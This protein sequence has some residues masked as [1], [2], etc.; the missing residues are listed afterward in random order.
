MSSDR[1]EDLL[2]RWEELSE[3]G[4]PVSPEELCRDCPELLDE[5]RRRV[6]A[7]Q[8]LNA[9]LG[10]P[11]PTADDAATPD[12]APWSEPG[13]AR[14]ARAERTRLRDPGGA[15]A[16][17]DGCRLQGPPPRPRPRRGP[18]DGAG[19]RP[20][21]R[22]AAEALSCRGRGGGAAVASAHRPGL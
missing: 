6:S 18:E 4:E 9:A 21:R 19:R 13:V 10:G 20:R 22:E 3:R 5:L 1:V 15:G 12:T 14:R 17:R 11:S 8:D 2:L 7:L 16:R